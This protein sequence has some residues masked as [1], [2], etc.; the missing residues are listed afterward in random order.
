[1]TSRPFRPVFIGTLLLLVLDLLD[2]AP[3]QAPLFLSLLREL[4]A[5]VVG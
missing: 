5:E 1:M 3:D 2:G 4:L